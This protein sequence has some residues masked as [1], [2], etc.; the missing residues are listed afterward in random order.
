LGDRRPYRDHDALVSSVDLAPT[1]LGL[2]GLEIPK[3]M[4]G[5][6]QAGWCLEGKGPRN[7]AVYLGLGDQKRGWRGFWD[8]SQ[9]YAE[10]D[11]DVLF[12]HD[13]DEFE[14]K[15]LYGEQKRVTEARKR[16]LELAEE[17]RDPLEQVIVGEEWARGG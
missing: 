16:L 6:S 7:S 10:G 14:R 11:Y 13:G 1:I 17:T 15:N 8:G 4:H 5:D 12:Q 9:V 2:A 3:A